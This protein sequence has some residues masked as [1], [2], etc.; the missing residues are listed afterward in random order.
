MILVWK[1]KIWRIR[2]LPSWEECLADYADTIRIVFAVAH[3]DPDREL[4]E[5]LRLAAKAALATYN[6]R[7]SADSDGRSVR[8]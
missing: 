6:A 8:G 2:M 3:D 1:T 4:Y 7:S 5:D